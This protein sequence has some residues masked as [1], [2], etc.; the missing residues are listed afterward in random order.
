MAIR[1]NL[2]KKFVLLNLI[3]ILGIG[4]AYYAIRQYAENL[5]MKT[6]LTFSSKNSALDFQFKYPPTWKSY[7]SQGATEKYDEVQ[8]M[9]P[10]DE[11]KEFSVYYS[12]TVKN[13]DKEMSDWHAKFI[14]SMER[15]PNFKILKSKSETIQGLK[16]RLTSYEHVMR[17]PLR[18]SNAE[19]V[20]MKGETCFLVRGNKAYRLTFFG[21][22]EQFKEHEY[23]FNRMLKSFKFLK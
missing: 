16:T 7:E 10:R 6:Y 19:S 17:L 12:V 4:G 23:V 2:R 11:A 8:V 5:E 3:L 22:A 18:K 20:L 13:S 21:T 9:G 15:F 14:S 1:I